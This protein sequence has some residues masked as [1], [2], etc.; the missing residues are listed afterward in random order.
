MRR[1]LI[2][3][4]LIAAGSCSSMRRGSGTAGADTIVD[5][6]NNGFADVVM[7]LLAGGADPFRLGMV[8]GNS[9][10]TFRI[11]SAMLGTGVLQLLARPIAQRS[12]VLPPVSVSAGDHVRVSLEST[13]AQSQ[14]V[15]EQ[16][17]P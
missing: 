9:S 4:L 2:A 3:A 13:P 15:V 5:V 16:R 17:E 14:V 6:R 8:S 11:R 1:V 12:Y 10:Q 7:Y